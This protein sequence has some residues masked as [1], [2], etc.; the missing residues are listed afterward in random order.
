MFIVSDPALSIGRN[1]ELGKMR[2]GNL[3]GGKRRDKSVYAALGHVPNCGLGRN[4]IKQIDE[5]LESTSPR[6]LLVAIIAHSTH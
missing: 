3:P 1:L 4:K 5:I 2:E 6:G